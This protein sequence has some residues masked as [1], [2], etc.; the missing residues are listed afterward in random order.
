MTIVEP[1]PWGRTHREYCAMFDL[2]GLAPTARVL[3]VGAGPSSFAA[4]R[5]AA[6]GQV[7]ACDPL[8]RE[9][10]AQIARRIAEARGPIMAK[11]I[12]DR[13][14]FV[15][16][17]I[18]SPAELEATRL[19]AMERFLA[20][21]EAGR[22]AGRYRTCALPVLDFADDAFDLALCSH[23]LFLYDEAFDL[24]FHLAALEE[25]LR[26]A[27]DVRVFP[28]L[29]MQGRASR[30]VTPVVETLQQRG[31]RAAVRRVAYEFQRGG[32]RMLWLARDDAKS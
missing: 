28:L 8:Y 16:R 6:G 25:L 9:S 17:S 5:Q 26:V 22:A 14:R 4:E 30:L 31:H 23:L 29:T 18:A 12:R 19:A 7:T 10:R 3:D 20:D 13:D 1:L 2:D 11:V 15:W 27:A 24:D 32:D 21:Y